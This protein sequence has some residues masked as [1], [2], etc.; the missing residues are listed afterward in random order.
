MTKQQLPDPNVIADILAAMERYP[1][2]TLSVIF[3]AALCL[4]IVLVAKRLK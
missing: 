3:L 1:F 4:G 2:A